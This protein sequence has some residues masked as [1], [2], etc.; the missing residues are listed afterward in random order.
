MLVLEQNFPTPY[1][2]ALSLLLTGNSYSSGRVGKALAL[3]LASL[4]AGSFLML[5]IH[6]RIAP[7]PTGTPSCC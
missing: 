1:L 5:V 6:R 4:I 2:V 3:T 7:K